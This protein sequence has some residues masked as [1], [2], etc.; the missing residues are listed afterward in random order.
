MAQI[1]PL[2]ERILAELKGFGGRTTAGGIFIPDENRK[3][4]GIRPR[5]A[6]VRFV[7]E[8]IDWIKPGQWA[9]VGHGRWSRQF[10]CEHDGESMELVM[11]DNDEIL[12]VL[13]EEPDEF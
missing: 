11:L 3:E 7:G 8:G 12:A 1:R 4:S 6:L 13:D 2:R 5:W 9:L 10:E